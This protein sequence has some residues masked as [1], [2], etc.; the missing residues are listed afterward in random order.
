MFDPGL[1]ALLTQRRAPGRVL[2]LGIRTARGE[3]MVELGE[4]TLLEQRGVEGDRTTLGRGS[5]RR[6]V[7]LLQAEHLDV[8][9]RLVG[10]ERVSPAEL[11]RNVVVE[12]INLLAM[13]ARVFRV[14]EVLLEGTGNCEPCSKMERAL[15]L[16]GYNAM[17]GHGGIL[18]RVLRGGTVKLGDEVDFAEPP[19]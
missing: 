6:Q 2:W 14:G 1:K 9:A 19:A 15:G 8:I 12:G 7:T 11:R 3:P 16:G 10:R 18:A 17:R 4:A 5:G 13:R